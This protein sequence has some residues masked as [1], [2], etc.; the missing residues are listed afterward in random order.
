MRRNGHKFNAVATTVD[1][2]RFASKAE[3]HR[4][5]ELK[6]L[7]KAGRIDGLRLQPKFDLMVTSRLGQFVVIGQYIADFAYCEYACEGAPAVL[8]YE[9]VKGVKTALYSWKKKHAETQYG[10]RITEITK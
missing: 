7:E 5:G 3:A 8:K 6:M 10:I 4:Y 1:G 9:D 2:V